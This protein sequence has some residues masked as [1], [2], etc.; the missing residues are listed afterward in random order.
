[1]GLGVMETNKRTTSTTGE[2][3]VMRGKYGFLLVFILLTHLS[4]FHSFGSEARR[5][6]LYTRCRLLLADRI[7]VKPSKQFE[8][9]MEQ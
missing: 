6:F 9:R 1:M 2:I 5:C 8:V 4:S 7:F 3:R